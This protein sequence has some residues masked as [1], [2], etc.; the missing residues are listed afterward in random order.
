MN[1]P[2]QRFLLIGFLLCCVVGVQA[3]EPAPAP[4]PAPVASQSPPTKQ[5]AAGTADMLTPTVPQ[6][7]ILPLWLTKRIVERTALF[8]FAPSCPH[9]QD[10]V[11]GVNRLIEE[12]HMPWLGVASTTS[13]QM[14]IDGFKQEYG[15]LFD[16]L[17]DDEDRGFS[18]AVSARSTPSVYVVEPLGAEVENAEPGAVSLVEQYPPWPR[19]I[20]GLFRIRQHL[21]DPF[22]DFDGYVGMRTC[23]GCHT[24]ESQSWALTHHAVAYRTLYTRDKAQDLQC[25]GCHVTGIDQPGGFV[26]G[27]HGSELRDVT[28]EA[29]HGPGGPHNPN[30]ERVDP[31]TTCVGCHDADH[32]IAFSVEKGLPH[33]DHFRS[34]GMSQAQMRA[35]MT[36]MVDGEA[37]RPLLA[38]PDGPTVGA[39]ACRSCHKSAY[40]HW[41][42][43]P[44][45]NAMQQLELAAKDNVSC[46]RCHAT[47]PQYGGAEET[48][49]QAHRLDESVGCEACHGAGGAH[50]QSPTKENI[51]GLGSSCPECVIES[52]CTSCHTPK[53]DPSWELKTR[54]EAAKHHP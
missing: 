39:E 10:A 38:F 5:V 54:L 24:Q 21:D 8:Y 6:Q 47:A 2:R 11:A 37:P 52:I 13:T 19:G 32:S 48:E 22:R 16:I 29:C 23:M 30:A 1:I 31:T 14:E 44:H 36:A 20:E 27:D 17:R 42:K 26:V 45:A 18:R 50:V 9:C 43:S 46:V 34:V 7:R 53:W 41:K 12:G 35:R 51:V 40:K 4:A 33:I 25:V 28:C 3:A 49:V 15:A